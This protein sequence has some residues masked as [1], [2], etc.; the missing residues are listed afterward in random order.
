MLAQ[1]QSMFAA[2]DL[3]KI[4]WNQFLKI[5][6]NCNE[7][8]RESYCIILIIVIG[9]KLIKI[10]IT[11]LKTT[12]EK[13]EIDYGVISFSCSFIRIGLRCIVILWQWHIWE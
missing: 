9:F 8:H 13:A 5:S 3:S 4:D 1:I 7:Y 12:L 2:V 10:L 11:L 6:G